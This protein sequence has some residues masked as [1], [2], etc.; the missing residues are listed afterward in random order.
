[1]KTATNLSVVA[2]LFCMAMN[3]FG[4][5]ACN[6]G[7]KPDGRTGNPFPFQVE[8]PTEQVI[9][10]PFE[11]APRA[12]SNPPAAPAARIRINPPAKE[13]TAASEAI[14]PSAR[15]SLAP[16]VAAADT[17]G[18]SLPEESNTP[19][20][21]LDPQ[22]AGLVGTWSTVSRFGDG[23]LS[24]IELQ[25]DDRGWA[26]LTE[27]TKDGKRSSS[28]HRIQLED[29]ELM[30]TGPDQ[31]KMTLGKLIEFDTRQMVLEKSEGQVTY[32]RI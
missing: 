27:P 3:A 10:P 20:E 30:L 13:T 1:M 24:T 19:P 9:A 15:I 26:T 2:I 8:R 32:V 16:R 28:K 21:S 17:V 7:G 31:E 5:S 18:E 12:V 25:L 6:G 22:L 23:E 11:T 4:Q 14:V 29:R